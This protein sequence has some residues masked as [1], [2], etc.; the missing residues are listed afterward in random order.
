MVIKDRVEKDV[1]RSA[2]DLLAEN[3]YPKGAPMRDGFDEFDDPYQSLPDFVARLDDAW[4]EINRLG[5]QRQAVELQTLGYTTIEPERIAPPEFMEELLRVTLD[6]AKRRRGIEYNVKEGFPEFNATD[7][8]A[9]KK[10]NDTYIVNESDKRLLGED[11]I[12]EKVVLNEAVLALVTFLIGRGHNLNRLYSLF[13]HSTTPFLPLHTDND[14]SP[15]R[16]YPTLVSATW[17]LTDFNGVQDGATCH[18]PGTQKFRRRPTKHEG[19]VNMAHARSVFA[20]AGSVILNDGAV[21]HGAP[22][23][24]AEGVRVS[25]NMFYQKGND[26]SADGYKGKE[27]EGMLERNPP[28]F[29]ELLGHLVAPDGEILDRGELAGGHGVEGYS[30]ARRA[31]SYSRGG[32]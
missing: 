18:V 20:P 26:P 6:V 16:T 32:L 30:T 9:D 23:R 27:P 2:Y 11:Q 8:A 3:G 29:A 10:V 17:C 19:Y 22:K 28:K 12:Y 21:W 1:A 25:V 13:R 5:L 31:A 24:L 4:D 15:F 14:L 7:R